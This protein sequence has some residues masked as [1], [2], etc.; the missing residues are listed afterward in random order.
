[1]KKKKNRDIVFLLDR[2]GS[3]YKF[4]KDTIGG[5]NSYLEKTKVK[6]SEHYIQVYRRGLIAIT[7]LI[8]S[9]DVDDDIN[10][11]RLSLS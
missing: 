6:K 11:K 9:Y 1:M 7:V 3:M 2:S 4:T 8:S 10:E 5:Y